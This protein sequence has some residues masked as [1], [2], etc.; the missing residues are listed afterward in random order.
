MF[1]RIR[2]SILLT[3][4]L[5]L[6]LAVGI[7]GG[8]QFAIALLA[9]VGFVVCWSLGK[10]KLACA[11][12][13]CGALAVTH[14]Q[15]GAGV[16]AQAPI[17]PPDFTAAPTNVSAADTASE[18]LMSIAPRPQQTQQTFAQH[19]QEQGI[20]TQ[21]IDGDSILVHFDQGSGAYADQ[22][23]EIRYIGIDAPEIVS[24]RDHFQCKG[25]TARLYNEML[26]LGKHVTLTKEV[27]DTDQ[28]HRLLRHV[29]VDGES[30]ADRLLAQGLAKT[31]TFAPDI[32][33]EPHFRAIEAYAREHQLG[34]WQR[35]YFCM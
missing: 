25:D 10:E 14:A 22:T 8:A 3:V 6:A 26:V 19:K 33:L 16:R 28:I 24:P 21:V 17:A 7:F 13:V 32:A 4:A 23:K 35:P 27:S 5:L 31:L 34:I 11:M 30:V 12:L 15:P 18:G 20:V 9:T 29:S 1:T 2:T